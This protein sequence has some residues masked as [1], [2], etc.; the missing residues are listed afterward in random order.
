LPQYALNSDFTDYPETNY[1]AE[2][3]ATVGTSMITFGSHGLCLASIYNAL[4]CASSFFGTNPTNNYT[5]IMGLGSTPLSVDLSR[6]ISQICVAHPDKCTKQPPPWEPDN[7]AFPISGVQGIPLGGDG[8]LTATKSGCLTIEGSDPSPAGLVLTLATSEQEVAIGSFGTPSPSHILFK[9]MTFRKA[10]EATAQGV[11]V[12]S[13]TTTQTLNSVTE[14]FTTMS[15]AI[16]QPST[17][18]PVQDLTNFAAIDYPGTA[19]MNEYPAG[20]TSLNVTLATTGGTCPTAPV[21]SVTTNASGQISGVNSIVTP[22]ACSVWPYATTVFPATYNGS[23]NATF[24]VAYLPSPMSIW[25]NGYNNYLANGNI[26]PPGTGVEM[27]NYM[28]AFQNVQSGSRYIPTSIPSSDTI[29]NAV[30][31]NFQDWGS[32]DFNGSYLP[33]PPQ[34]SYYSGTT[35]VWTMTFDNPTT[36]MPP[37]VPP[38]FSQAG[39]I[40]CMH[41]DDGA[42]AAV[43][44]AVTGAQSTDITFDSV[45]WIGDGRSTFQNSN[46]VS[47][48]NSAIV[49]DP[50]IYPNG[51]LPCYGSGS[52]GPQFN[53]AQNGMGGNANAITY[54]NLVQNFSATGTADDSIAFYNDVGGYTDSATQPRSNVES[55]TIVSPDGHPIRLSN[56]ESVTG[57]PD[58]PVDTE[59]DIGTCP[60]PVGA[61]GATGSPVCVDQATQQQ[62]LSSAA[63]CDTYFWNYPIASGGWGTGCPIWYSYKGFMEDKPS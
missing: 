2:C 24:Y 22:A 54:G 62:I 31:Q 27:S 10:Q 52:G 32:L 26:P 29:N 21:L 34:F 39:A 20:Q 35:P 18:T 28:R 25:I 49:R 50:S 46:T 43:N 33:T 6:D 61:G 59:L 23:G 53:P 48:L 47:I 11:F 58:N 14:T 3:T 19:G 57:I 40:V 13:A 4:Y 42:A 30:I 44:G 5:I 37:A 55:S 15:L 12:S 45:D 17:P 16:T 51:Q 7:A 60:L 9:N 63:N 8:C 41:T 38:Y 1:S 56:Q 36:N